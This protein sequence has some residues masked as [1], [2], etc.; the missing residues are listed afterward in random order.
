MVPSN[1]IFIDSLPL[2]P[3]G[4][5]DRNALAGTSEAINPEDEACFVPPRNLVE[6]ALAGIWAEVLEVDRIS[7]DAD[8]FELGGHS[9]LATKLISRLRDA[10]QLQLSFREILDASTVAGLAEV[11]RRDPDERTKIDKTAELLVRLAEM[12]DD[13]MESA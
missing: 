10:F 7:V 6:L 13:E 2:A 4:K 9:L 5:I 12:S 1:I 3:N 11:L 8:F